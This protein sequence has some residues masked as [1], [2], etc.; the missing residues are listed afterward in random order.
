MWAVVFFA[1]AVHSC[2]AS[3]VVV[4]ISCISCR[5]VGGTCDV[6]THNIP[7]PF[8]KQVAR[9]VVAVDLVCTRSEVACCPFLFSGFR[10][11]M[12]CSA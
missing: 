8:I 6:L 2:P 11:V 12:L 1:D 3:F 4:P 9:V 7:P 10:C 5:P